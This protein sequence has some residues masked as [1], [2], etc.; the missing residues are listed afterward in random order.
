MFYGENVPA[1][2]ISGTE[3]LNGDTSE[4]VPIAE[5]A[6]VTAKHGHVVSCSFL[7]LYGAEE[8]E[9]ISLDEAA[10]RLGVERRRIYDIV[11]VLESIEVRCSY[12]VYCS[13]IPIL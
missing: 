5:F 8:G 13:N 12:L 2:C 3:H 1:V 6:Q 9:C 7:N 4:Q 10:S 11:N